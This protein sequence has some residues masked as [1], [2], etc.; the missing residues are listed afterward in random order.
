MGRFDKEKREP[1]PLMYGPSV[2]L[3]RNLE[4]P[5][6]K[7]LKNGRYFP[8]DDGYSTMFGLGID[9]NTSDIGRSVA[10]RARRFGI[11]V[12]E[13]NDMAV[14]ELRRHDKAI[15]DALVDEGYTT[16]PDTISHGVRLLGAQARY[17][18]GN[19][20]P[21]FHEWAKAVINGDTEGQKKAILK[22]TPS[23]FTDRRNKIKTFDIYYGGWRTD[24]DRKGLVKKKK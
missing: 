17:N 21:V 9:I 6:M 18:R 15:M 14:T 19:I 12:Q 11:P 10:K 5:K 13:G 22:H 23:S 2:R 4:N 1:K 8:V 24:S 20:K 3:L 16:R 7:G